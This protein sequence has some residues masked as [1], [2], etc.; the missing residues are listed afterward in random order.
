MRAGGKFLEPCYH[1]YNNHTMQKPIW[2]S[3]IVFSIVYHIVDITME[4]T[5]VKAQGIPWTLP[6]YSSFGLNH[7]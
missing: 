6:V 2:S 3:T 1:S 7:A 4:N 5:V